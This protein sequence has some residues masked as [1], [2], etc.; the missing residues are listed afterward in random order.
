MFTLS[1]LSRGHGKLVQNKQKL[2]VY[3]EPEDYLNWKSPEDYVLVSKPK[4]EGSASPHTWSLF[5]PKTFSTRKGALIL[6]SEGLALSAWTPEERRQGPHCPKG[7]RKRPGLELRTLQ[8]L[9]KAILAYG[10]REREQDRAWQPYLHF[11]SQPESQDQRQMQPGYSAK[12]YLRGLLRTWPPDTMPRLQCAGYIK[13]SVLFQDGQLNVPKNLRSQQDLSG[14]PPKYH[15]LPVF[16]PFWIQQGKSFEQGQQGLARGEAGASGRMDQGSVA[17]N[18]SSQGIHLPQLRKQP[19]QEA[20]TQAEDASIENHH[21]IHT[22][23]QS[24]SENITSRRAF[25]HAHMDHSWL[26]SDKS[27]ITFYGGAF[28]NRK[29]DLSDRQGNIR[30]HKGRS[31]HL[32]QEPPA[33]RCLFP[34][35]AP[36]TGSEKNTAGEVKKKKV[37][38]ALKLP[39]LSEEQP[40]VLDPLRSEPPAE[41]FTFPVEIHFHTQQPPK[42]KL[43]GR[44]APHPEPGPETEEKARPLWKPPLKHASLEKPR[45][46]TVHLPMDT[47]RDTLSHQDDDAP[48]QNVTPPWSLI[49]GRKSPESPRGLDSPRTSSCSSSIGPLDVRRARGALPA[50]GQEDSRDPT[51]GH[52]LPGPDGENICLFL[53]RPTETKEPLSGTAYE[54]VSSNTN[55]EKERSSIQRPLKTNTESRTCLLTNLN[56]ISPL[57]QKPEKQG[58]QQS[59]EAA[60]QKI[61]EPQSCI[62]KGL[63]CSNRKEFYTRKLHID[64]TP[65]LKENGDE[66]DD[67]EEPEGP[68]GE[69]HQD[70][71]DQELK[72]MTPDPLGASLADHMQP[73][74]SDTVQKTGKDYDVHHL[75]RRRPGHESPERLSPIDASFFPRGTEGRA[76]PRLFNHQ[77]LANISVSMEL[78]GKV[79]RK[80]RTKTDKSKAPKGRREGKVQREAEAAV[81][82]SKES[83]A[84]KKSELIPKERKPR[85]KRKRTQKERNLEL[86]E[87]SGPDVINSKETEDTSDRGFSPADSVVEDPWLSH[88][89][90]APESQVS[91]DGRSSPTQTVPVAGNVESKE[92][93]SYEDP[94]KALLTE[95]ERQ[96]ATR[97][98][99]RAER[100]E[101]RRS[102]V[103]RRRGQEARRRLLQEQLQRAEE[104]KEDLELE[105]RT[106]AQEKRLKKERLEEER[107]RQEEAARM[108]QLQLQVAQERVRRQR[109]AFQRKLRELQR[110][111]QQEEAERAEDEKQRQKELEMQLAEEEKRLLE[112]AEEERLEHQQRKQEAGEKAQ[113]EAEARR[114]RGEEAARLD[115][116]GAMTRAQEEA[117]QKAALEKHLHFHQ[118]LCKEASALRWT[119]NISRSWVYSYFQFLHIPRP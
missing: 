72:S 49:K 115:L 42:E 87:L 100:A 112:M 47:G 89:Y 65:F 41:L 40:R 74:V 27:H 3:F 82:K 37:P 7:H 83:K 52:F 93:R 62:N 4:E 92:E 111:K 35:I 102:E 18:Y 8:D 107:R 109:E 98:R 2:E 57:T 22:S 36:A 33:E 6:Y 97:D 24:H 60:A 10:R 12:R 15:L 99:L 116:E 119:H 73:P 30:L 45:E 58:A 117:R 88:K 34:P 103:E 75:H 95:R 21:R 31:C 5:L 16:P 78:I 94:S 38:K 84:E 71:Q 90:D 54:S 39:P 114:R 48:P 55:H 69:N 25:G 76:E 81:G 113:L 105:L 13:D 9:K 104:M 14:V 43:L 29:A 101:R 61:G 53:P 28:P 32:L 56:E 91:I 70:T 59:L 51:L 77:A 108:Q 118:D 11:R 26:L 86:A 79:K 106:R 66:L 44:A 64:M 20:E 68:L 85:A 63:I 46:L 67:H 23:K 1:L 80:K 110:T 96:G 50:E 17:K 19:W